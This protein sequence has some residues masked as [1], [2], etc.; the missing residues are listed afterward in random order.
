MYI[1]PDTTPPPSYLTRMRRLRAANRRKIEARR[2]QVKQVAKAFRVRLVATAPL[3]PAEPIQPPPPLAT[4]R[5]RVAEV[6]GSLVCAA[7]WSVVAAPGRGSH[8]AG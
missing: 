3:P 1:G 8:D 2:Q 4:G 7:L 6:A 5:V